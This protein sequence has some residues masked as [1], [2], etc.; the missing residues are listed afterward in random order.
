[1]GG[2]RRGRKRQRN[3]KRMRSRK[4]ERRRERGGGEKRDQLLPRIQCM[5]PWSKRRRT[6]KRMGKRKESNCY[7]AFNVCVR[8]TRNAVAVSALFSIFTRGVVARK[9]QS[10]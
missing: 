10:R 4:R 7:H 3:E 1:M 5:C 2:R 8:D 9:C 6:R